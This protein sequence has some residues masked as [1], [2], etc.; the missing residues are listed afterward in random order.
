MILIIIGSNRSGHGGVAGAGGCLWHHSR[1][2]KC[3][4]EASSA[5]TVRDKTIADVIAGFGAMKTDQ[6]ARALCQ[7]PSAREAG[8]SG[9]VACVGDPRLAESATS[10]SLRSYLD[11]FWVCGADLERKVAVSEVGV[12]PECL[13]ATSCTI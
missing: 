2:K 5:L 7:G 4:Q 12:R 10:S 8:G 11:G 1:R 3:Q 13:K 6:V 9:P